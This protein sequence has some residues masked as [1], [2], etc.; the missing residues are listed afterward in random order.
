MG[1][2]GMRD[3]KR[4]ARCREGTPAACLA[5]ETSVRSEMAEALF[6]ERCSSGAPSPQHLA[7]IAIVASE[8][9]GPQPSSDSVRKLA[10]HFLTCRRTK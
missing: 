4:N 9:N 6:S 1:G 3:T 10:P 8:S 5:K 2:H 7:T